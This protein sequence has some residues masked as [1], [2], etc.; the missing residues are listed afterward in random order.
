[1]ASPHVAGL[2]AYL[3]SETENGATPKEIK[4]KILA[5]ASKDKLSDIGKD[6]PN[7][8]IY[9]GYT[10]SQQSSS[11]SANTGFDFG[12]IFKDTFNADY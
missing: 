3:L 1:M 5:L 2:A 8:L 9:N 4:T 10:E 11:S 7:L 12:S 6:S